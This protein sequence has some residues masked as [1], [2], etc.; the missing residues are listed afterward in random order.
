MVDN[1][2]QF[3]V[4]LEEELV[5]FDASAL[6]TCVPI[7]DSLEIFN[8]RL[9]KGLPLQDRTEL[10]PEQITDLLRSLVSLPHILYLI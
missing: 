7:N 6:F 9:K 1:L 5:S 4:L 3:T 10:T 2:G 8:A